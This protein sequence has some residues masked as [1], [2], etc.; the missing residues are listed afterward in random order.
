MSRGMYLYPWDLHEEGVETVTDRLRAAA[1]D[2]VFLATAYHAGKFLR[3]HAPS[4]KVY[5][6]HDGTVYFRPRE[7]MYG[8]LKPQ[9][10]PLV[11]IFDAIGSLAQKAPDLKL[12]SWTVGLHNTRLG[13]LHDDLVCRTAYGDPLF[14]ALCPSHPEVRDFL[15]SLCVDIGKERGVS[16]IALET[17]GFQA[18]R[19]GHHHEFEL[20]ELSPT[21][22][23]LLGLC[24]CNACCGR[25][26]ESGIDV[27]GLARSART[28]LDRFFETGETLAGELQ[29]DPDWAA[30]IDWRAEVVTSLVRRIRQSLDA[31]ASLAVI[32]TVQ[33]PNDL[34]WREGSDLASLARAADRLEV[35]AYQVGPDDIAADMAKVRQ[36]AGSSARI[37]FILRPSWPHL[38]NVRDLRVCVGAAHR[39]EAE[40]ISFYNYGHMRLQ[41]LDWIAAAN[42]VHD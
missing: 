37:G 14:N 11:D 36:A 10:A 39:H 8:R 40:S 22:E 16:E 2:T 7:G 29:D 20:V 38:R 28:A 41:S 24:F 34:C 1:I 33:S 32:P 21:A 30:F 18:Y 17:P 12:T 35:P 15:V 23:S 42:G 27:A 25:A 13:L 6:P 4:G 9:A 3:P 26:R 5:F 31:S 19:H